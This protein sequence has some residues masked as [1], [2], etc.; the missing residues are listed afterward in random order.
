MIYKYIFMILSII[1]INKNNKTGLQKTMESVFMQDFSDFEYIVIDGASTDGSVE[2]LKTANYKL[3]TINYKLVSEPDSGIYN[4]MNK[5]IKMANGEYLLFLNSGDFLVDNHVLSDVFKIEFSADFLCGRCRV[6]DKGKIIYITDPPEVLSLTN[7]YKTTLAHQST[8]IKRTLFEQF[9]LY[10]EDL[11]L[12]SDWEFWIRT[13]ILG[14][15]STIKVDTIIA[16]YN[17]DGMSSSEN[18]YT[19]SEKECEIVY[20]DLHLK[21][22]ITDYDKWEKKDKEMEIAYWMKSKQVLYIP[23]QFIFFLVKRVSKIKKKWFKS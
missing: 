23:I 17:L 15:A 6:S 13:I 2:Y 12:M 7:F 20:N 21:N 3:Q 1:T 4:A 18:N 16:D 11:K 22:I 8:F 19:L 9:G 14:Y 5:G 10:R